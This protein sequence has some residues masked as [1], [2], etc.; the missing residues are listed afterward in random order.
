MHNKKKSGLQEVFTEREPCQ[1]RPN[2]DRW[3]DLHFGATAV[4]HVADYD[5]SVSSLHQRNREH[6]DYVA[7]LKI[8]HG[9]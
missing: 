6:R 2:C 9:R 4:H 5:A 7:D 8:A 1:K 3:L